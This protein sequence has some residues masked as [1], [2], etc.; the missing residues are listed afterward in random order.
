[1][2]YDLARPLLF[3]LDPETAH[4]LTIA[5]LSRIGR[6]LPSAKPIKATPV[7]VMGIA[8]PNR[9]GLAAGLDKNGAAIDGLARMGF[10]AI[11]IGTVTPRPQPGNPDRAC[12]VCPR[13]RGSSIAWD[14][15]TTAWTP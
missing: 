8:F 12:S 6:L 7:T 4:E 13:C 11:E 10:G 2:L 14:S 5:S 3:A 15:T 9:V 1:M